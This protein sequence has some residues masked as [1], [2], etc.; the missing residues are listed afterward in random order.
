MVQLGNC[1]RRT[2]TRFQSQ[3]NKGYMDISIPFFLQKHISPYFTVEFPF[4]QSHIKYKWVLIWKNVFI[5]MC[6]FLFFLTFQFT[7]NTESRILQVI[8]IQETRWNVGELIW[9][10]MKRLGILC[11]NFVYIWHFYHS[12]NSIP[13]GLLFGCAKIFDQR[14]SIFQTHFH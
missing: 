3:S 11:H 7:T 10:P 4:S 5:C 13:F 12:F 9:H 8:T 6:V 2:K 14:Y 1:F